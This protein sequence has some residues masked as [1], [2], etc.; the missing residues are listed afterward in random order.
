MSRMYIDG[1]L[2]RFFR[3]D[4]TTVDMELYDGRRFDGLEPRRLFPLTGLEKYIA[5]LDADGAERG[6]IRDLNT[7]SKKDRE[8]QPLRNPRFD[9]A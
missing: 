5:L 4:I 7:L 2:A 3:K 6:I 9:K 8:R 1:D